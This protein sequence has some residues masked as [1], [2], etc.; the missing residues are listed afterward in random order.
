MIFIVPLVRVNA[1]IGT[2]NRFAVLVRGHS[3]LRPRWLDVKGH[4]EHI[5]EGKLLPTSG[6]DTKAAL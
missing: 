4:A 6:S 1:S 3:L 2:G 5:I